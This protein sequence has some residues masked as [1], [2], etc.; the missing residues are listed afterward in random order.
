MSA[1]LYAGA[2]FLQLVMNKTSSEWLYISILILLGFAA[3]FTI[4][5]GLTA[6]IWTDFVQIIL[7]LIGAFF[8]MV[9]AFAEVGGYHKMVEDY[10]YAIPSK[11]AGNSSCGIPPQD[12]MS[13]L[14]SPYP[15]ES[16]LPWTG[17]TFGLTIIGTYYFSTDQVMVQRVLASKNMI[18]AKAGCVLASYLK[19]LPL[20]LMVFP[21]MIARILFPDTIGCSDPDECKKICGNARGC[22][23]IAYPELVI[24]LLPTG[25]KGLMVAVMMASLMSSLTSVFN[26]AS[27]IFTIDIWSRFRKRASDIELVIVGRIFVLILVAI[28]IIWIPVLHMCRFPHGNFMASSNGARC[29]LGLNEWVSSG[30]PEIFPRIFYAP[31][32]LWGRKGECEKYVSG[33]RRRETPLPSLCDLS[34][35]SDDPCLFCCVSSH[36]TNT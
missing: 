7:M 13:L 9:Y 19:L 1:D 24:K 32:N 34:V 15:S 30:I 17:M 16:D 5:G 35:H 36:E 20:W 12:Y 23:N 8:L 2:L 18:H 33:D 3:V 10:P 6:V 28:S 4:A 25:L 29:I 21:G 11:R 22:S 27:T 31:P 26:S 14:R